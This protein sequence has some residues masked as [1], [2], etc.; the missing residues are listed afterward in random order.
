[1]KEENKMS[2]DDMEKLEEVEIE[3]SKDAASVNEGICPS[4][5][6]RMVKYIDNKN[7][8]DGALTFHII[9]FKCLK[10]KKEYLDLEE[11]EK[12]DLFLKLEKAGKDK[13]LELF[14][15]KKIKQIYA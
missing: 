9:K 4:C 6:E 2:V 7:L 8:F 12:Y 14:A 13:A 15:E 5:N 3:V 10:C 11:A 1:M